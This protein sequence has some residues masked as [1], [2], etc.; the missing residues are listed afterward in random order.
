MKV[1]TV[2][3]I[4]NRVR[5]ANVFHKTHSPSSRPFKKTTV[6]RTDFSKQKVNTAKVNAV[7][8]VGGQRET[9]VK[10]SAGCNWRPQRN[11]WHNISKYNSGSNLRNC[12]TFKDPLGRL[13]PQTARLNGGPGLLLEVVKVISLV[14]GKIIPMKREMSKKETHSLKDDLKDVRRQEKEARG[15]VKLSGKWLT[16]QTC[17]LFVNVR[18]DSTS[19]IHSSYPSA[20]I[21]G[22]PTSAVQKR[23][24]VN[25]SSGAHAFVSYVQK[26]KRTNHLRNSINF[27]DTESLGLNRFALWEE[28]YRRLF[29]QCNSRPVWLTSTTEANI[30]A[31]GELLWARWGAHSETSEAQP[32]PSPAHT[33]EVPFEP[34]TDSS[35]A[36]TSEVPLWQQNDPSPRPSPSTI[37]P[38]SIPESFGGNLGGQ[39]KPRNTTR[40]L[41]SKSSK[42][43]AK[44]VIKITEHGAK[45][46]LEAK[47]GKKEILKETMGTQRVYPENTVDHIETKNAQDTRK[48][49]TDRPIV[50]TDGSKVSTD[51]QIEGTEE[52]NKGTDGQRKGTE[53]HT[54]EGSL[55]NMSQAKAV[56]REK[57][58]GVELKDIEDTDRPRPTS[59]RSLLTL[60]PL[61]KIDPKDKGKMKI[62]KEDESKR[63]FILCRCEDKAIKRINES[64]I[65]SSKSEVIKEESKEEVQKESKEEESTRKRKLGTRKKMKSRKRRFIQNTSEDDSEKE[66][67][68]AES[69]LNYTPK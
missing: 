54:E 46:L 59:T 45:Y 2:K 65:D 26:Q 37:I 55:L 20:L 69:T 57:E 62:E 31:G 12:Y 48:V 3:P 1:N 9:A 52:P 19:R 32:I 64:G 5:P 8:T 21:L 7:S 25:T 4:V 40:R 38:D 68:I 42:S 23:S 47:I 35:P 13:K 16:S 58:K 29:W 66:N 6:L 33:S 67:D 18:P 27:R 41:R 15:S 39:I 61:L 22:D 50:S 51:K 17:E 11:N 10:S 60:K 53:D 44:P 63:I 56:S 14:K 24:K 49:S 36:H 30:V 28:G 34:H 43:K